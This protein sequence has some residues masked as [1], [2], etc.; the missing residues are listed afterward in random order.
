VSA[1][2]QYVLLARIFARQGDSERALEFLAR[3]REAGFRDFGRLSGDPDFATVARD[4][5]FG[6]VPPRG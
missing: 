6:A 5:R 2:D 1:A 4:P 3:A